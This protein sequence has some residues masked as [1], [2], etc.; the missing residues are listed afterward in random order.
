MPT[1]VVHATKNTNNYKIFLVIIKMQFLP[2][3]NY[4]QTSLLGVGDPANYIEDQQL[5]DTPIGRR[6]KFKSLRTVA[7][8]A[9]IFV[10]IIALYD[11]LR[12]VINHYWI[13][14]ALQDPDSA[15]TVNDIKRTQIANTN[16]IWSSLTF[17]LVCIGIA[18]V[19]LPLLWH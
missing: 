6:D 5:F 1:I 4:L 11:V 7:I 3:Q 13:N 19:A 10:T 14:Q 17:A 18:I 2:Q 12:N 15:N 9:I 16:R 8:S